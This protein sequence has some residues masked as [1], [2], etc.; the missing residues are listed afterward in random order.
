MD[1]NIYKFTKESLSI[2]KNY[3]KNEFSKMSINS[4][5]K[6]Y[7][8]YRFGMITNTIYDTEFEI[9]LLLFFNK[10][11]EYYDVQQNMILY[12]KYIDELLY[13]YDTQFIQFKKIE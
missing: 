7:N 5:Y 13:N 10:Y 2:I 3:T 12:N 8:Y 11:G 9:I 1:L 4:T 6:L